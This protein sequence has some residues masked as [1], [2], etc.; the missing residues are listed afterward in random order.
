MSENC[1]VPTQRKTAI[2]SLDQNKIPPVPLNP[3]GVNEQE[4]FPSL[5]N[6]G[7]VG[8]VHPFFCLVC[9][10]LVFDR[11]LLCSPG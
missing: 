2:V 6:Q 11:L 1:C 5:I 4:G 3:P 9:F 7:V 8:F 10:V